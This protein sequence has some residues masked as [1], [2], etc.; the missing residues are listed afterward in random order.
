[1]NCLILSSVSWSRRS[2]FICSTHKLFCC[3]VAAWMMCTSCLPCSH[4]SNDLPSPFTV[5]VKPTWDIWNHNYH[6]LLIFIPQLIN[7]YITMKSIKLIVI[8]TAALVLWLDLPDAR[9]V[10]KNNH[11]STTSSLYLKTTRSNIV[12]R[13]CRLER[14]PVL[15]YSLPSHSLMM[16]HNN[17]PLSH[18]SSF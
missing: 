14:Y 10:I 15:A 12:K 5:S 1:M 8:K 17:S 2:F 7:Y 18:W 9:F 4:T 3:V 13:G 16:V 6:H 11:L